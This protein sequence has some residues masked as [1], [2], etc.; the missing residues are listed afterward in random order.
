[1]IYKQTKSTR[2]ETCTTAT[3]HHKSHMDTSGVEAKHQ[4]SKA[5]VQAPEPWQGQVRP[6]THVSYLTTRIWS[7]LKYTVKWRHPL[8]G[9]YELLAADKECQHSTAVK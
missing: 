8:W 3:A 4:R 5:S 9:Q 6:E 2:I 7:D 1:M